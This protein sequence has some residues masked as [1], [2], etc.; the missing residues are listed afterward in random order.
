MSD[1]PKLQ[2]YTCKSLDSGKVQIYTVHM[3]DLFCRHVT[4][5]SNRECV[6]YSLKYDP[7]DHQAESLSI[8]EGSGRGQEGRRVGQTGVLL[9]HLEDQ[10]EN[11]GG[12]EEQPEKCSWRK[13]KAVG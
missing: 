9:V 10:E 6:E 4:H 11:P 13:G 5:L 3:D 1:S 8:P 7:E 2:R 12:Q